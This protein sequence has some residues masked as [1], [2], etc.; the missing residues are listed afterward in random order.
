MR[1]ETDLPPLDSYRPSS[2]TWIAST[3]TTLSR[4][5]PI[6]PYEGC[7]SDTQSSNE[8]GPKQLIRDK[9]ATRPAGAES[10]KLPRRRRACPFW[11][12]E[13]ARDGTHLHRSP[14][15]GHDVDLAEVRNG[16][17]GGR[18]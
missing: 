13:P 18:R 9:E 3:V 17:A 2:C 15:Y 10:A 8:A 11:A 16:A 5:R 12:V 6:V 4:N 1:P 7:T 14:K